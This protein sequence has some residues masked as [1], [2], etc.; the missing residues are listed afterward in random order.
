MQLEQSYELGNAKREIKATGAVIGIAGFVALYDYWAIKYGHETISRAVWRTA[1]HPKGRIPT[2]IVL[3]TLYKHLM[4]PKFLPK[5]DPL[6]YVAE[7]W[8]VKARVI[9]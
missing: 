3:T 5:T 9:R 8:H 1:A 7:R 6:Y 2:A 4:F